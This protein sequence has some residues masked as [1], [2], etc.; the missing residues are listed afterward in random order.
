[1]QEVLDNIG[2]LVKELGADVVVAILQFHTNNTS[3]PVSILGTPPQAKVEL[4]LHIVKT[5]DCG[6]VSTHVPTVNG[7][8]LGP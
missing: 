4:Q 1:M 3:A 5:E 7:C 6:H 8:R 2:E